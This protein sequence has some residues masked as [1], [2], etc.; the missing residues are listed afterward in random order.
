LKFLSKKDRFFSQRNFD[1]RPTEDEIRA[2]ALSF[3]SSTGF[4]DPSQK[5]DG[6]DAVSS[7]KEKSTVDEKPTAGSKKDKKDS[8]KKDKK[9]SSK[10][11]KKALKVKKDVPKKK[12]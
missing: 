4:L 8:S 2:V 10:K 3:D 6:P 7:P 11:V 5:S 1:L 9:D 12:K